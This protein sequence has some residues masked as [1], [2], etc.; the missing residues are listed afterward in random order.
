M[1]ENGLTVK[2]KGMDSINMKAERKK[3]IVMKE[4]GLL[5]K[6]KNKK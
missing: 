1:K 4:N 5:I 6:S 3:E 2:Y